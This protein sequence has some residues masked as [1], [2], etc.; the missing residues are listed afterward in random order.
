[1]YISLDRVRENANKYMQL[2][3]KELNRVII[4]GVLHITGHSDSTTE[5]REEMR[6]RENYYLG[7]M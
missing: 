1:M 7:Q 6:E 3:D 4:H 2:I 5:E